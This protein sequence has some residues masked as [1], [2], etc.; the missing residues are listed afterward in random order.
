MS[1]IEQPFTARRAV[2]AIGVALLPLVPAG[3]ATAAHVA[4]RVP[5][6]IGFLRTKDG[7]IAVLDAGGRAHEVWRCR[8]RDGW[9]GFIAGLAWSPNGRRL[10]LSTGEIAARS[11]Y[12]GLHVVDLSTGADRRIPPFR[13]YTTA[14]LPTL[15]KEVA[16]DERALGCSEPTYLAW[17]PDSSQLAYSCLDSRARSVRRWRTLIYTIGADGTGRRLVSPSH[18]QSAYGATWSPDG[19]SIAFS[20]CATPAPKCQSSVFVVDLDGTHL[21]R[22]AAGA[23]P[24]WSPDGKRIAYVARVCGRTRIKLVSTSGRDT[25]PSSGGCAGIGPPDSVA[26]AWSPDGRRVAVATRTALFVVDADGK[27]L[28]RLLRGNFVHA[29]PGGLP[30]L[31]KPMWRSS[32]NGGP[33]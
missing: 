32:R 7:S 24:D 31:L 17:S 4:R 14:S 20:T 3:A 9:C 16:R 33:P 19:R 26:A 5:A 30:G 28:D 12:P 21:H 11:T 1:R 6:R 18:F 29:S 15:R 27:Q 8:R 2:A 22:L 13:A 23:L 10:A 25:T